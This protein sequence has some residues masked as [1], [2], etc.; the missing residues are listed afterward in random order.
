[1]EVFLPDAR[2]AGRFKS[3]SKQS[4]NTKRFAVKI[5]GHELPIA[6]FYDHGFAL[7]REYRLPRQARVVVLGE[8]GALCHGLIHYAHVEDDLQHFEF[9]R[10]TAFAGEA[11]KDYS[12][13]DD[14]FS[15]SWA[16]VSALLSQS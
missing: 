8:S 11:P 13:D 12:P 3:K 9:K 7:R 14:V 10:V 15:G 1:M 6:E 5:D 4:Q 2:E 16:P